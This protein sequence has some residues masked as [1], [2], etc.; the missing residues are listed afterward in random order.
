MLIGIIIGSI[1]TLIIYSCIIVAKESDE[2][3]EKLREQKND[4]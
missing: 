4:K 1:A 3:M 2:K